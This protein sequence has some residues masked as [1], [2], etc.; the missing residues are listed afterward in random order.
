MIKS[1]ETEDVAISFKTVKFLDGMQ[2]D[3]KKLFEASV[4]KY[5]VPPMAVAVAME[6]LGEYLARRASLFNQVVSI[7][8]QGDK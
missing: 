5:D 3:M 2:E 1:A 6:H 4:Q 8:K 7:L